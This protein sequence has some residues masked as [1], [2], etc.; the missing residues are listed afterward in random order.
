M[1]FEPTAIMNAHVLAKIKLNNTEYVTNGDMELDSDWDDNGSPAV[2]ERS[3]ERAYTG[4]YS[5][6]ITQ[7]SAGGTYTYGIK[8]TITGLVVG[9]TYNISGKLY[10]LDMDPVSSIIV[11]LATGAHDFYFN[12]TNGS[13]NEISAS[14]TSPIFTATHTSEEIRIYPVSNVAG[15]AGKT[16]YVDDISIKDYDAT[17][18]IETL[19]YADENLS[20]SDG[21]FYEGRLSVSTLQ[22]AFSSFTQP[23]QRTSTLT[24][25]LK[26]ADLTIRDILEN[27]TLGNRE[28]YLYVGTGTNLDD[29]S[30]DFHGVIKFPGG[31]SF[32]RNEVQI[33]LNDRRNSDEA[34]LPVNKF[35]TTDYPN[36]HEDAEGQPI[37]I[38][39]GNFSDM[40]IP[41]TCV[42]TSTKQFKIADHEIYSID[43]VAKNGTG[44]QSWTDED[45]ENATF[46]LDETYDPDNDVITVKCKGKV[47]IPGLLLQHPVTILID[48]LYNFLGLETTDVN[49]IA[50]GT[51]LT[52]L[53]GVKCRRVISA[54]ISSNTLLEELGIENMFDLFIKDDKY[55]PKT[56]MPEVGVDSTYTEIEIAQGSLRVDAD[57]EGLY[58]NRIKCNYDYDLVNDRYR[59][60]AQANWPYEQERVGQII[61][62]T[63]NFKWLYVQADVNALASHLIMLYAREINVIKFTAMGDA[64]MSQLADRVGLTF[65]HYNGRPLVIRE[66][67]K[68]FGTMS[69]TIFGYDEI[70]HVLPGYWTGDD[71]PD[72]DSATPEQRA[73]QGFWT[74]DDGYANP[75]EEESK[76]SNFW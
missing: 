35:W 18:P 43:D 34:I 73:S 12:P 20:M 37:P 70:K 60:I 6:K 68:H 54:E 44:S 26:D 65:A 4:T 23:K 55:Y 61:P 5:R 62:R 25:T 39:Y 50:L 69:C 19:Y 11:Y 30:I 2:N 74:D 71:A 10:G 7:P 9:K 13:W 31:V 41:A 36:L 28:V 72:Y 38:V 46:I 17:A 21:N 32:D 59:G 51:L 40:W 52:D 56:R 24:L 63:I 47:N 67:S 64:I 29:Y 58:A 1:T 33:R 22:R 16:F 45:L 14:I 3:S 53:I 57:P 8:Q 75:G 48:I 42:N 27:Y 49:Q 66:L 76:V 15:N